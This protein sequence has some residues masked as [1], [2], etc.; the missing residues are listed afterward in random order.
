MCQDTLKLG[1]FTEI[2]LFFLNK[3]FDFCKSLVSIQ[4]SEKVD[5]LI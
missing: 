1:V 4:K 5:L 2:H 3:F